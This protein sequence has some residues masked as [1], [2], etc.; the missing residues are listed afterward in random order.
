MLFRSMNVNIDFFRR[1]SAE[2]KVKMADSLTDSQVRSMRLDTLSRIIKESCTDSNYRKVYISRDLRVSN[3]WNS[4][5]EM[6]SCAKRKEP[7]V[8]FY[9]QY[10][11]TDSSEAVPLA[12]LFK[13][14]DL[15]F[16]TEYMDRYGGTQT[17]HFTFRADKIVAIKKAIIVSCIK[18]KYIKKLKETA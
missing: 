7:V 14:G 1:F 17:A 6:V 18:A 4:E 2:N 10:W 12:D 5:L 3:D 15:H 11:N 9:V 8:W 16:K 13:G